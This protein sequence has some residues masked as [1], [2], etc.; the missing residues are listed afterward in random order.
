METVA[1]MTRNVVPSQVL[2]P[3]N[4]NL[5]ESKKISNE[6]VEI[7]CAADS[8]GNSMSAN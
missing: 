7:V 2:Q 1:V 3:K 4:Q 8:E 6:D 5:E